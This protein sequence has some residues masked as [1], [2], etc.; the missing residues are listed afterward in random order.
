MRSIRLKV[1]PGWG[2]PA[3]VMLE[4]VSELSAHFHTEIVNLPG[5][6]TDYPDRLR[7]M[8][9]LVDA[10]SPQIKQPCVLLGWSLGGMAALGLASELGDK[11]LGVV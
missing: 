8:G 1:L 4:Y 6:G 3:A 2:L 7:D 9:G 5:Y 10:L 11:A